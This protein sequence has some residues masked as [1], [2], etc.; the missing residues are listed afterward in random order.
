[1][2]D[3][4][5]GPWSSPDPLPRLFWVKQK[6]IAEGRK[7]SRASKEKTVSPLSKV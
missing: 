2:A 3:L 7:A 4:G 6:K 5:E 1:V